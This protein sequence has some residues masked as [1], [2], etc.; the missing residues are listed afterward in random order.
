MKS[1][2]LSP[3]LLFQKDVRYVIPTFQR[4]YVWNQEDQWEPLWDDVRNTAERYLEELERLGADRKA[5]AERLTP[6][7]FFGAV[8]LQ[9]QSTP[10]IEIEQRHV[11]DGQQRL[12]TLQLLLDA[13][14][15]VCEDVGLSPEARR[16]SKLVANDEDF[17]GN[18]PANRFKIW[19][20]NVDREAFRHAM[21][22]GLPTDAFTDSRIVQGHQFFQLQIREW[23]LVD[24]SKLPHRIAALETALTGLLQM[25]VIDLEPKDDAHV[26]FETLNARGTPLIESDLIKNFILYRATDE[27]RDED[28][29]YQEY[30]QALD[31]DWWRQEVRQGRLVRPRV[32]VFLNYWL[33]MRTVSDVQASRV[34]DTFQAYSKDRAIDEIAADLKRGGETYRSLEQVVDPTEASFMYRWRVMDAGVV[35]PAL[36]LLFGA[37]TQQLP[38]ERRKRS[39]RAIESF[40]VRRM[41]CRFTTKDYNR[42]F[43]DLAEVLQRQGLGAADDI[44]IDFL[45]QQRADSREW[46]TDTQLEEAFRTLPLY[47][48]LTRGRLR[49]LLEGIEAALRTPQSETV[50]VPR[51]LTIEHIM[52]QGWRQH[53]PAPIGEGGE[54][55]LSFERDRAVHTIGNLT[56][57][58]NK[59][60]PELSNGPWSKKREGLQDHSTLFLNKDLLRFGDSWDDATIRLRS[61]RLARA[62]AKVWPRDSRQL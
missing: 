22:N 54:E 20:T 18:D 49:L 23:L 59:L 52:P 28:E 17:V 33:S 11:I 14:Q 62:A 43:L 5:D 29:A 32:D 8:V 40:L 27:G 6:A 24:E 39:L 9:Q 37:P 46:P 25:V 61:S 19:P 15:Q 50:D 7:H 53:W 13:A 4:P 58:N 10:S 42:L 12:T 41:A 56:L 34:F 16:L 36:L 38:A 47:R 55:S 60:N 44:V 57:L 1:D 26:I 21:Q 31:S 35:T 51:D 48:L 3:K 45:T 2:I 30:W